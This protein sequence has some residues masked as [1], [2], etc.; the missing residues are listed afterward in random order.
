MDGKYINCSVA[1]GHLKCRPTTSAGFALLHW[2]PVL[3]VLICGNENSDD[4]E[5]GKINLNFQHWLPVKASEVYSNAQNSVRS[6]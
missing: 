1:G 4:S 6:T 5:S 2:L 3:G